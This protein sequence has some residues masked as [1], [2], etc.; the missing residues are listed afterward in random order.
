MISNKIATFDHDMK[1]FLNILVAFMA[2]LATAACSV[3]ENSEDMP[4]YEKATMVRVGDL[5]PDFS[6]NLLNGSTV[7]LSHLQ[8]KTVLLVFFDSTCPDCQA[9]LALL[10][11]VAADF[12]GK[13]FEILAIS[14]GEKRDVVR[15]YIERMGYKFNVGVDPKAEIYSMYAT[16]YVPRC[17]VIDSLGRIVALSAE[18]DSAEF[19][20][21]VKVI[22][23][24]LTLSSQGK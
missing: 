20:L 10:D 18:Y 6:A 7:T 21:I 13:K 17:F 4:S 22:N 5:A 14:R 15:E 2:L 23:S 12:G 3:M 11:G 8:D 9:Q 1:R 24:L 19:E 16:H